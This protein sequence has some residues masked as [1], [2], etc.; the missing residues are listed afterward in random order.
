LIAC[1]ST[2]CGSPSE[3]RLPGPRINSEVTVPI[4]D[5]VRLGD[6]GFTP[7]SVKVSVGEAIR[8]RND[9]SRARR[10]VGGAS[11]ELTYDTGVM[12]PG[13]ST[14]IRFSRAGAIV[15]RE[16]GRASPVLRVRV[17]SVPS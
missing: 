16:K 5:Q 6:A 12:Q 7:S 14:V 11:G 17:D 10:I 15:L 2:A 1:L 4:A 13:D 9:S 8:L 3:D